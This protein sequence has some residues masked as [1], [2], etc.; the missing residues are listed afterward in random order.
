MDVLLEDLTSFRRIFYDSVENVM[1]AR[2]VLE[3]VV[4]LGK[5]AMMNLVRATSTRMMN[6]TYRV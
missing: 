3:V 4:R 5:T 1:H 6:S 2:R